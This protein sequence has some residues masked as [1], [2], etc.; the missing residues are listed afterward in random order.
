MSKRLQQQKCL[1]KKGRKTHQSC[2]LVVFKLKIINL[3]II[4][5]LLI[6]V[7]GNSTHFPVIF[8]LFFYTNLKQQKKKFSVKFTSKHKMMFLIITQ[9]FT[10]SCDS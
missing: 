2:S 5:L 4:L 3:V 8:L 7:C 1:I 9:M 6:V 10:N